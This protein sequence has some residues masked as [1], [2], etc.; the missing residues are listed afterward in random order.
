MADEFDQHLLPFTATDLPGFRLE[1]VEL[2]G[3]GTFDHA[4]WELRLDGRTS[5]LTG[6]I[7]SGKST[8][9]DAITTLLLPAHR[10]AYNKAAGAET[11]ERSLRSYVLGYY[12]S[13]RSET[14]GQSRPVP[15]RDHRRH[16]VILAVFRHRELDLSV[17]LAQ[18]FWFPDDRGGQPN[19]FYVVAD[20]DLT[21]LS[22]FAD[23]GHD[24]R[25]LRRRLR[26]SGATVKDTF[27]DYDRVFR[28]ALG[29]PSTQAM[30]L[31][32]QTVS[33]KSVG[34]LN[35]FVR[36]HMLEPFDTA[37]SVRALVDHFEDLTAAHDAVVRARTQ[38][39]ALDP[40]VD[41]CDEAGRLDAEAAAVRDEIDGARY[42][43][44]RLAH[45]LWTAEEGNLAARVEG[46]ETSIR[47]AKDGVEG[48]RRREQGLRDARAGHGGGRVGQL[49]SLLEQHTQAR[50]ER[51]TRLARLGRDLEAAGLDQL[52][53]PSGFAALH[54]AARARHTEL[55]AAKTG[56]DARATEL[57]VARRDLDHEA[58][59]IKDELASLRQRRS[60]VP[61]VQLELR[62]RLCADLGLAEDA[63]PHAGELI[64]VRPDQARWTGAAERVLRG[65]GLSLLV[66]EEAYAAVAAWVDERHLGT[67]MVYH[68]VGDAA[69]PGPARRGTL[70]VKLEV[71]PGPLAGWVTAELN[72]RADHVCVETPAELR[73]VARGVTVNGQVRTGTRHEKD[74]RRPLG[75]AADHVLGWDNTA[76]VDALID[77]GRRLQ[78]RIADHERDRRELDGRLTALGQRFDALT[79]VVAVEDVRDV[80]W[81]GSARQAAAIEDELAVLRQGSSELARI[82]ADLVAVG[83][84]LARA[85]EHVERLVGE[86]GA[87]LDARDRAGH[88]AA[89]AEEAA[90]SMPDHLATAVERAMAQLSDREVTAAEEVS[91]HVQSLTTE[92]SARLDG[93]TRTL[94]NHRSRAERAMTAFRSEWPAETTEMDASIEA[95]GEYRE[96]RDR[97]RSDD[98]PRFEA[99]FKAYLNENAIREIAA[100]QARLNQQADDIARRVATINDSLQDIDYNPGRFIRLEAHP[101]PLIEVKEFRA[102]LRACTEGTVHGE[103][104]DLYTE[105]KFRQVQQIVARFAG[106]EGRTEI[107][108]A[109]TERVTDVRNWFVFGAS[110]RWR[111][112]GAE[113]ESYADSDG[114]SG[115]QKEK[116]AYTILAAS[117]AYQF[118]LE[119]PD[120]R[121]KTFR[122]A[123]I[124]EAFGR[125]S[126]ASTRYA[127]RLFARLGLQLLVIT[128]LQK[129]HTI[130]PFVERV[131]FVDNPT[132]GG[133]RLQNLTIGQ[134]REQRATAIAGAGPRADADAP[135]KATP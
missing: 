49:E 86:R 133:S 37:E 118:R 109:W 135:A 108:R 30:D 25:V 33:M 10:I 65:F 11:R 31:F 117:L 71:R 12:K 38:L 85:E 74:D 77:R 87:V 98:L 45:D 53:D 64:Q 6:D 34:N 36:T 70:A 9:V 113:H 124:D 84:D 110:E 94:A 72:R 88:N 32:H 56:L 66:P 4:V 50:Q 69:S 47:S 99:E 18:V 116:L 59:E 19:R 35:D 103:V 96:L 28:R 131:G 40:I 16:S 115:G 23:F 97:L 89:T 100:F 2:L 104:D 41:A 120:P 21:I 46:I 75:D 42:A 62:A 60:S 39:A 127:L 15:L 114:K 90:G 29:I 63:L 102:D 78:D 48:L 101:T 107:D 105:A 80:D 111:G 83:D 5:L 91:S 76:K 44:A 68:R 129:V 123:V 95:A 126:D 61:R 67:R 52:G 79:R 8:V 24:I 58:G 82:E 22:H 93:L 7:G 43:G 57:A 112:S 14:T 26:E 125:G 20:A 73:D 27:P 13:E 81:W 3:W 54:A 106:R 121:A 132:G 1:R 92:L 51:Q 17:T 134:Y 55:E 130:E 128:P 119:E 122:F